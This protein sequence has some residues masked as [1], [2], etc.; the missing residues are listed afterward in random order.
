MADLTEQINKMHEADDF[1]GIIRLIEAQSESTYELALQYAR[2]CIN[3][4]RRASDSFSLTQKAQEAL[5]RYAIQG[6]DDPYWLFYKGFALYLEG[7]VPESITRLERAL[8]FIKVGEDQALF[9]H[10]S[11][12]AAICRA[13]LI[14]AEFPGISPQEKQALLEHIKEQFGQAHKLAGAYK[15]DILHVEPCEEH[16]YHVLMTCGLS[17]RRLPVPQGFD[18]KANSRLELCIML[19]ANYEF[20]N[21][22]D[23]DWPVFLLLKLIE[24][25]ISSQEFIGFG[26][27]IDYGRPFSLATNFCG[28]MLTALGD[29][30]GVSQ[31]MI[32]PSGEVVH[33]FQVVPLKRMEIEYRSR[34][35]ASLLLNKFK[36]NGISLTPVDENRPD[37][38]AGVDSVGV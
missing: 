32:M 33:F 24:Q 7:L 20:V 37:V 34:H 23:R 1:F 3:A 36:S 25:I 18:V 35:T 38:G 31:S 6:K 5:D 4:A 8:R 28:L 9:S 15:V 14:E 29:Y 13:E 27:Y 10:V 19:P 22:K 30:P 26:Y 16:P 2:A 21:D 11:N 12:L 17:G